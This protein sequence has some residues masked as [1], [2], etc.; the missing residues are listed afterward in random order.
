M[1]DLTSAES[2]ILADMIDSYIRRGIPKD[3]AHDIALK[4]VLSLRP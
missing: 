4:F 2:Y 3:I 1:S